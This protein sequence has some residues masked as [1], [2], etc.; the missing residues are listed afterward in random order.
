MDVGS[1]Y[2]KA[3]L[4]FALSQ[5]LRRAV[6]IECVISRHEIAHQAL[7]EARQIWQP[8]LPPCPAK[9]SGRAS[10]LPLPLPPPSGD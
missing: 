2:G 10:P 1:G 8:A 7:Q 9:H 4:H 6:G 3:V 5:Q